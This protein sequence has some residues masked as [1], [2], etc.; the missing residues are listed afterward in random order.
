MALLSIT[1]PHTQAA[2]NTGS[3]MRQVIYATIP[4]VAALTYF[5]GWGTLINIVFASIVALTFEA[6]VLWLRKK[7][8][9]FYLSDYSAVVTAVLLA[10][11][12]PPY[13]PWWLTV[14][15]VGFAIVIAKQLYGGM[16][17][18]PFNP[19][20]IGYVLLL[21]SY[22]LEMTSWLPA[23]GVD[24]GR[25]SELDFLSALSAIFISTINSETIDAFTMAT[26]LDT[27]KTA[28]RNA[29][30]LGEAVNN[31]VFGTFFGL[32]IGK[33]WA[34][35]NLGFLVGGLYL[36]ARRIITWHIP[37]GFL[38]GLFLFS[39]ISSWFNDTYGSP[40]F[41]IISGGTMLGAF[42]IATDPVSAATSNKGRLIYGF[43][44]GI[45]IYIIRV[46]GGYPDAVAFAVLLMNLCAPTI[47]YY[48]QPRAYGHKKP[49]RTNAKG[50]S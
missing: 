34:V 36:I 42:F 44:I 46:W 23:I 38:T 4:G 10:I 14:V 20:M 24:G 6:L 45:L 7:P 17:F 41:H 9:M 3:F 28:S 49:T 19:A 26:P 32:D 18:N 48:T 21:I 15:G 22:P 5:F 12:I 40:F 16:G 43:G 33:G 50:G 39:A 37:V 31:P 30:T 25:Q 13:A 29:L 35:V 8:I 27:L 47:D 11:A 1:S 2:G